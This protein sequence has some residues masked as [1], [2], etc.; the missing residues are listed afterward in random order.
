[1]RL[2]W[3]KKWKRKLFQKRV[4]KSMNYF[5]PDCIYHDH[6]FEGVIYRGTTCRLEEKNDG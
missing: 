1:M 3:F 6:H 2:S 5:C 4:C